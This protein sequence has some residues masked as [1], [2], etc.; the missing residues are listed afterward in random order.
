MPQRRLTKRQW[1]QMTQKYKHEGNIMSE[2]TPI[3]SKKEKI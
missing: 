2:L 1:L 3:L